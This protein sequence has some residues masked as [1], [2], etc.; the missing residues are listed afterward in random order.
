M[1]K[2]SRR[3]FLLRAAA[4]SAG[5]M[6]TASIPSIVNAAVKPHGR[7]GKK[8]RLEKES[9]ILFQGDSI[10]DNGRDRNDADYNSPKAMGFGYAAHAGGQLLVSQAEYMPR[11]F[12]RGI[13]GNKVFQ[14]RDRWETDCFDLKPDVLSILIGVND[15]WHAYRK[16][17]DGTPEVYRRDYLDLIDKT[18]TRLPDLQLV[19]CEP[20]A[21][22]G[23][24]AATDNWFPAFDEMRAAA[25]EVAEK[26]N[27]I[28]VPF[29]TVFDIAA[30]VAP[31]SYWTHDGVHSSLAGS[32]LMA[33][34][35]LKATG[36]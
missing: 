4:V 11:I 23:V 13:S 18:M 22:T 12:N 14:L 24:K 7:S 20:F 27:A 26:Y 17:Y 9:V 33:A 15:F 5:A 36:L 30:K 32:A 16:V 29:Q 3:D 31:P 10:T 28:F 35:W 19:I 8:I 2:I 25:R 34:A 6:A 1:E 21:V